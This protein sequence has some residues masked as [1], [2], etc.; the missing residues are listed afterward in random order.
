MREAIRYIRIN[1]YAK[2]LN[3]TRANVYKWEEQGM[4]KLVRNDESFVLV[5]LDNSFRE[6]ISKGK[7]Y[8]V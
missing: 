7:K 6:R 4:A 3:M 8:T 1:E 5:D 2:A